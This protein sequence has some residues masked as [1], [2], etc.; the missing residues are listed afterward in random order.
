M[1]PEA[2]EKDIDE[3]VAGHAL[4]ALIIGGDEIENRVINVKN[5]STTEQV[6]VPFDEIGEYCAKALATRHER[7]ALSECEKLLRDVKDGKEVREG[8]DNILAAIK[9]LRT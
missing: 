1:Q 8:I 7:F 4:L 2:T 5:L 6:V 9:M 3:G